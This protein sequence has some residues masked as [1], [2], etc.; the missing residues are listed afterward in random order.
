MTDADVDGSHIRTL[1]LTFF[2]RQYDELIEKGYLYI[3]QPPLFKVRKGKQER[4]LKDEAALEDHLDRARDR[5]R[6]S[7]VERREPHGRPVEGPREARHPL[8]EDHGRR[9]RGRSASVT[10]SARSRRVERGPQEWLR[11]AA[12]VGTG[13]RARAT[14][15]SQTAAPEQLPLSHTCRGRRRAQHAAGHVHHA[16]PTAAARGPS[17][18]WSSASR[19]SSRSCA[20]W[21]PSCARPARRPFA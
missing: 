11:D 20:A 6:A 4:Y 2:Y 10:S 14:R 15:I 7:R 19:R 16:R 18:T 9:R 12:S 17:S 5:G 3:A 21:R 8:R 1:L 13:R